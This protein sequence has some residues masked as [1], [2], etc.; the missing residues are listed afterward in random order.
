MFGAAAY[1]APQVRLFTLGEIKA[2]GR[3]TNHPVVGRQVRKRVK[4]RTCQV[5]YQVIPSG[6]SSFRTSRHPS[7]GDGSHL[8]FCD[9]TRLWLAPIEQCCRINVEWISGKTI[10]RHWDTAPCINGLWHRLSIYIANQ[11]YLNMTATS[12]VTFTSFSPHVFPVIA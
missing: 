12:P 6:S 3:V 4:R 8:A 2:E 5:V 9:V 11:T 7:S 10:A 1:C